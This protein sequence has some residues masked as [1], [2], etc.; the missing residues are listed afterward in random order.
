MLAGLVRTAVLCVLCTSLVPG[1]V[2][3]AETIKFAVIEPLSGPFA[4]I[5]NN[6][7][8][9]FVLYSTPEDAAAAPC[10]QR[11]R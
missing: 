6:G 5:G 2:Y 7:M 4:N 3:A 11:P 8:R 9:S 1:H 10:S